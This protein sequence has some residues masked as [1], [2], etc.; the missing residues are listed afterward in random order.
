MTRYIRFVLAHRWWVL[1]LFAGTTA[2]FAYHFWQVTISSTPRELFFGNNNRYDEYLV[3]MEDHGGDA[4]AIFGFPGKDATD[5]EMLERLRRAV[6]KMEADPEVERVESLVSAQHIQGDGDVLDVRPYAELFSEAPERRKELLREITTD[7]LTRGWLVTEDGM[8]SIVVVE[9]TPTERGMEKSPRIVRKVAAALAEEGFD[10]SEIHQ[11]GLVAVLSQ[12]MVES[13]HTLKVI[14]PITALVLFAMVFVMFHRFWPVIITFIITGA[15]ITWT[16]GLA[17]L[18]YGHINILTTMVP[19]LVLITCFA[20]VIHMCSSYLL[21]LSLGRSKEKAI[22]RM[23]GEVGVACGYTSVTTFF[24]FVSMALVPTPIFKQLGLLMG[25]GVGVAL[26]MALT[27]VP[28]FLSLMPAPRPWRLG[29]AGTAQ[30]GLD[31]IL[32][33]C[34]RLS[35]RRPKTINALFFAAL[36]ASLYGFAH[37]HFETQFSERFAPDNII[38]RGMR[39]FET[40]FPG[41]NPLDVYI[42]ATGEEDLLEPET[43]RKI[44]EY[45]AWIESHPEVTE[46]TTVVDLVKKVYREISPGLAAQNPLPQSREALAQLL[47]LFEMSG[48]EDL[49]RFIGYDHRTVRL[50]VR[51]KD[52][53]MIASADLG[54]AFCDEGNRRFGSVAEVNTYSMESLL[55][56]WVGQIIAGQRNGLLF[57]LATIGFFM[58]L[59]TRSLRVGLLSMFPN[60]LPLLVL[61]GYTGYFWDVVDTDTMGVLMVAIGIGVDDTIHFLLRLRLET[62]KEQ[63][64]SKAVGRTFHYSGRAIIITSVILVAGFSPFATS[65]YFSVEIFGKLLP[66]ALFTALAA[67]LLWVP[68]LVRLGWIRFPGTWHEKT[69]ANGVAAHIGTDAPEPTDV[70]M[71]TRN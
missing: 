27:L 20:D 38:Q 9:L 32:E 39:Y 48:G 50:A 34:A 61:L 25:F 69:T 19:T 58:V 16:M 33:F 15:A 41:V 62:E 18:L 56:E 53:G 47:L 1:F 43:F 44:A 51:L 14:L 55:G 2:F 40:A 4:I 35:T 13:V 49:V 37:I 24:G 67:D 6:R 21:E 29:S 11:G 26:F 23:G 31:R 70:S 46:A 5:P 65:D 66:A 28:V 59:A 57:A 63:D 52:M 54:R 45:E 60:V 30:R 12:M 68:A 3:R 36:A 7:S 71:D 8:D 10:L 64:L 42:D 17:M 22:L